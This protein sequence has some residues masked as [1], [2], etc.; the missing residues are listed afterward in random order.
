MNYVRINLVSGPFAYFQLAGCALC[1]MPIGVHL[2]AAISEGSIH[3]L[4]V[5]LSLIA[6]TLV[7][8]GVSLGLF[9]GEL[10]LGALVLGTVKS[11]PRVWYWALFTGPAILLLLFLV[12]IE[13]RVP[14]SHAILYPIALL[15]QG[16]LAVFTS[17]TF[18]LPFLALLDRHTNLEGMARIVTAFSIFGAICLVVML[19]YNGKRQYQTE[20]P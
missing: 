7:I 9:V 8:G 10:D 1:A 13:L 18:V 14:T 4:F 17:H 19:Y 15:G 6:I 2:R 3:P 5:R 20:R 11:P 16:A 12:S